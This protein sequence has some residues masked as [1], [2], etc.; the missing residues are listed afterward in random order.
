MA[1]EATNML[2]LSLALFLASALST[3][4]LDPRHFASPIAARE[5]AHRLQNAALQAFATADPVQPGAFVAVL[6]V[7]EQLLVVEA[8]HPATSALE[9]RIAAGQYREAYL[10]LQGTPTPQGRFFVLDA[11]ADGLLTAVPGRGSVDVIDEASFPSFLLNG[12]PQGQG[13]SAAEYDA[14]LIVADTKYARLL[15]L[16]TAALESRPPHRALA[17]VERDAQSG[18][19]SKPT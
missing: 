14:R 7:P 18:G 13:M 17:G 6:Y 9:G 10:D 5:L 12:D 8:F 1:S 19:A 2:N 15:E 3:Q 16:L 11:N 4:V